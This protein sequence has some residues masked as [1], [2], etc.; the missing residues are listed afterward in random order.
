MVSVKEI[1]DSLLQLIFPHI[2][3]GCGSDILSQESTLCMRCIAAMPETNF[4]LYPGNPVEK[5]FWGRLPVVQA[6]AQYYFTRESLMQRLMHQFKYKRNK[7][8]GFQLGNLMGQRLKKSQ[9]YM[10]DA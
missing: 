9:R 8:L 10:V 5:R 4:E 7:E 3:P 2:C 1:K 6:S